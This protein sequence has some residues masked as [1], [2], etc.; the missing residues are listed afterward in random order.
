VEVGLKEDEDED[1]LIVYVNE[2][3]KSLYK[4]MFAPKGIDM[5]VTNFQRTPTM[6]LV[7]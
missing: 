2:I 5:R 3:L 4:S 7:M 6:S 1:I